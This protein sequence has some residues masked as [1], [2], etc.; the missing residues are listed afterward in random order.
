MLGVLA[1]VVGFLTLSRRENVKE[2]QN[3]VGH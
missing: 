1:A 3:Y 2:D